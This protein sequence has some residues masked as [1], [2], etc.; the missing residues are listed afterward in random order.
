M[1]EI[2][3]LNCT[4][5]SFSHRLQLFIKC[6][7][8]DWINETHVRK[9]LRIK[10]LCWPL[11]VGLDSSSKVQLVLNNG[12][13]FQ[14]VNENWPISLLWGFY[15]IPS[16]LCRCQPIWSLLFIFFPLSSHFLPSLY[17]I[18]SSFFLQPWSS[19]LKNWSG[20]KNV[21][22]EG[23][24]SISRLSLREFLCVSLHTYTLSPEMVNRQQILK[25]WKVFRVLSQFKS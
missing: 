3:H 17:S 24:Q 1:G 4:I 13:S 16:F 18:L 5:F 11:A 21:R 9:K 2:G 14:T 6:F 12:Q 10:E 15:F 22:I 20:G 25:T 7:L 23:N 19:T 8:A